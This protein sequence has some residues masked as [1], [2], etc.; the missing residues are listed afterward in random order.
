MAGMINARDRYAI[1]RWAEG[2]FN[3]NADGQMV[4][5]LEHGT[6]A[7]TEAIDAAKDHGLRLPILLRFPQILQARAHALQ[8]GFQAAIDKTGYTEGYTALYPI[9]VNQQAGVVQ[10]FAQMDERPRLHP[11]GAG[12]FEVGCRDPDRYRKNQRVGPD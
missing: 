4:A 7:L 8:A 10:T 6:V 5:C 1:D 2:L 11:L 9:K 12:G 3:I